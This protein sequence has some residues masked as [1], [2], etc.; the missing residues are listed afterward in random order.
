[1]NS[2][3]QKPRHVSEVTMTSGRTVFQ[4]LVFLCFHF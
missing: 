3:G 1:M 2:I 4:L